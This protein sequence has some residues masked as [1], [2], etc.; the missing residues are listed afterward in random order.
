[1]YEGKTSGREVEIILFG[2]R[3]AFLESKNHWRLMYKEV[4]H[5]CLS[6]HDV[7]HA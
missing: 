5:T 4:L 2:P 7:G 3:S 1:M 6:W